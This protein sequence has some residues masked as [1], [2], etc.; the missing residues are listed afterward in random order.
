MSNTL[1]LFALLAQLGG[2]AGTEFFR[3]D[4]LR[5]YGWHSGSQQYVFSISR[6][7]VVEVAF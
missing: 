3:R 7:L 5:E 4:S 6:Y 2:Q 1:T